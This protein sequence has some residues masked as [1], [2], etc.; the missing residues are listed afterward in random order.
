MQVKISDKA[1]EE[2][3]QRHED[4]FQ[5]ELEQIST[6][7]EALRKMCLK[8]KKSLL[9]QARQNNSAYNHAAN[10]VKVT[11]DFDKKIKTF[12]AKTNKIEAELERYGDIFTQTIQKIV[13]L[14]EEIEQERDKW[15]EKNS[16]GLYSKFR[17]W[18]IRLLS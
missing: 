14:K 1:F 6:D 15:K 3:I 11:E 12:I 5:E 2:A 9:E 8:M 18:I 7:N 13:E 10:A 4:R 16:K 17:E